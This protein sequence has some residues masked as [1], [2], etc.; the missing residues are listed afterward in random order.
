MFLF[1]GLDSMLKFECC[2]KK[3]FDSYAFGCWF[4]FERTEISVKVDYAALNN[5]SGLKSCGNLTV[6]RELY[7]Q[8]DELFF[9]QLVWHFFKN[10][11]QYRTL[12]CKPRSNLFNDTLYNHFNRVISKKGQPETD[13]QPVCIK[14]QKC[15]N[16][17]INN[18]SYE[19]VEKKIKTESNDIKFSPSYLGYQPLLLDSIFDKGILILGLHMFRLSFDIPICFDLPAGA[20]KTTIINF[21]GKYFEDSLLVACPTAMACMQYTNMLVKTIHS[22]FRID[23]KESNNIDRRDKLHDELNRY[24][25]IIFDEFSM[26]TTN[27]YNDVR[28]YFKNKSIFFIGDSAQ[29]PPVRS[30]LITNKYDMIKFTSSDSFYLPRFDIHKDYSYEKFIKDFRKRIIFNSLPDDLENFNKVLNIFKKNI[31]KDSL[32]DKILFFNNNYKNC[33]ISIKNNNAEHIDEITP[34]IVGKNKTHEFIYRQLVLNCDRCDELPACF[35]VEHTNQVVVDWINHFKNREPCSNPFLLSLKKIPAIIGSTFN[36]ICVGTTIMFRKNIAERYVYN[37]KRAVLVEIKYPNDFEVVEIIQTNFENYIRKI[38]VYKGRLP[39]L[40]FNCNGESINLD[41]QLETIKYKKDESLQTT[42]YHAFYL[43]LAYCNTLYQTQG[44]TLKDTFCVTSCVLLGQTLRS[45]YVLVS[46]ATNP[47][48][49][50]LLE[51]VLNKTINKF[52][53]YK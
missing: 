39:T 37:G 24:K 16:F 43:Q 12:Q 49:I 6:F 8:D 23:P 10:I 21:L 36:K 46:R 27:L 14:G 44:S 53:K 31:E 51:S 34:I 45:F 52:F 18:E 20:G 1:I 32:E 15:V 11:E 26:I 41:A 29:L 48:Q 5:F 42:H 28:L 38:C 4:Y 40:K 3:N 22:S 19:P 47:E 30:T 25:L 17:A 7:K 2:M 9:L 50:I 33:Y 35:F 13:V